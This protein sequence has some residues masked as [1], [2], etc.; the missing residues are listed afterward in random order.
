[1]SNQ[2][3]T[4]NIGHLVDL[5]KKGN[6]DAFGMIYDEL[7]KPIYRYIYYRVDPQIAEDLTEDTFLK[8]W[9][10]LSK[11]KKGKVPFSAWVFKIAHNLVCDYYRKNQIITEIDEDSPDNNEQTNPA[12]QINVKFNQIKLRQAIKKLPENYQQI[13]ILKYINEED[14]VTISKVIEKSEGAVRTLQFRAL[15]KLRSLLEEKK[16]DF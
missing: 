8:V 7:V 10:N 2:E 13:I 1:M 12:H 15:E 5:A 11:Y 14:N 6:T 4:K 9:Q 3:P 16:E